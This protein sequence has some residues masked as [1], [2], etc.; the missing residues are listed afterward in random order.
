[1]GKCVC[2]CVCVFMYAVLHHYTFQFV[3][4]GS[5]PMLA[6]IKLIHVGDN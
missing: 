4:T 5:S 2:V 6:Q 1:M 3:I